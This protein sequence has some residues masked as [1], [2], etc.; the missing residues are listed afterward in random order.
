MSNKLHEKIIRLE[1]YI[2][3][4]YMMFKYDIANIVKVAENIARNVNLD[5]DSLR[6]AV[7]PYKVCLNQY[8]A[9]QDMDLK[10]T[11][12]ITPYGMIG[13]I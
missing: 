2:Q 1:N 5:Y 12:N 8:G 6:N 11:T 7:L 10:I 13:M 3:D 9:V 4:T